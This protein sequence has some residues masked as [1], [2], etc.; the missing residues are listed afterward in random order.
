M[1]KVNVLY[2]NSQDATFDFDYY[3]NTHL[4]MVEKLLGDAL[5]GK[6]VDAGLSVVYKNEAPLYIAIGSLF[7]ASAESFQ[8]AFS[9]HAEEILADLPNF[10]NTHPIVQV[11]KQKL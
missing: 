2:P 6:S 11:N 3:I 5:K 4:P 8:Q 1:I 10:T 9:P 7:F